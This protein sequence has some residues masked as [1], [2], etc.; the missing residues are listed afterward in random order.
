MTNMDRL[1]ADLATLPLRV[2]V[3]MIVGLLVIW[4]IYAWCQWADRR[5][6]RP[7]IGVDQVTRRERMQHHRRVRPFV[8]RG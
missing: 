3:V 7:Y 6:Q 4:G 1:L 8:K 5:P 2:W